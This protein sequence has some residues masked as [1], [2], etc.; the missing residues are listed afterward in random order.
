MDIFIDYIKEEVKKKTYKKYLLIEEIYSK[1][2]FY[3]K[4]FMIILKIIIISK[5]KFKERKSIPMNMKILYHLNI[6]YREKF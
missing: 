2:I 1:N 6:L 5:T 4:Y 3:R